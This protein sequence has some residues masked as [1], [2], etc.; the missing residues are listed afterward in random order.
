[1]KL[2]NKLI[3]AL[4]A[5]IAGTTVVA[6][7]VSIIGLLGVG[8]WAVADFLCMTPGRMMLLIVAA[9]TLA[10][11]CLKYGEEVEE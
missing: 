2:A 5:A 1:M 10:G 6:L 3:G 9:G 4:A 11:F 7:V 8:F